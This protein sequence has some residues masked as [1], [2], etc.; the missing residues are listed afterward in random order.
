MARHT[1]HYLAIFDNGKAVGLHH[2]KRL[3]SPGQRL[4]LYAKDRGCS[5]PGCDVPGYLCEVHHV[6]EWAQCGRTDIDQ[7]TFACGSH[8]RLVQPGGWTTRKRRDALTEWLPPPHL[9]RGQPRT[10]LYHHPEELLRSDANRD[11]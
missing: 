3:A 5:H 6:R 10:N 4:V 7:L 9:D 11:P 8:H 2:A 1:H